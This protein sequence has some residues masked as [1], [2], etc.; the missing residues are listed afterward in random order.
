MTRALLTI[1]AALLL[2]PAVAAADGDRV[3]ILV[4]NDR[5]A[6]HR[7]TLRFAESDAQKM[8]DVLRA[9]GGF[10][11]ADVHVLLGGDTDALDAVLGDLE[12]RAIGTLLFYYSGHS[13]GFRLELGADAL[14]FD[15]LRARLEG[16]GARVRLVILDA[17]HSGRYVDVKGMRQGPSFDVSMDGDLNTS[18]TAVITSSALG[19]VSQESGRLGGGFFTHHLVS[20]LWGAADAD[21]DRVV[22]LLEA[23]DHA[24]ARTL[25]DTVE[26]PTGTQHP[27]Y[28]FRL[29]G[30]GGSL[31]MTTLRAG[32]A[33][34]GFPAG[35]EG[36]FFVIDDDRGG[37]VA[38]VVDPSRDTHLFLPPGEYRIVRRRGEAVDGGP[39]RLVAGERRN[40]DPEGFAQVS[41]RAADPRGGVSA[42]PAWTV[43]ALYGIS[44][45]FMN[46][47]GAFHQGV[48]VGMRRLGPVNLMVRASWGM[49]SVD[50]QGFRYDVQLWEGMAGV[51][52]R[53]SFYK[54]DLLLGPLVGGGALVQDAGPGGQHRASTFN[55]GALAGIDLWILEP[56]TIFASW[57]ADVLLFRRGEALVDEWIARAMVGVGVTF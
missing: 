31:P 25:A 19:E 44:S 8:A 2:S 52:W 43:A 5:G 17:C 10:A 34:L 20:G 50:E 46:R 27:S 26:S 54:L 13:D 35:L 22:T 40:V 12:G 24:F 30:R 18:G 47:M 37:V 29:K 48:L 15:A 7:R 53:F 49:D 55:A 56:L 36:A 39:V 51:L 3:A 45:K 11:A 6:G 16:T 41:H 57:E 1:L 42:S 21:D 23:Y 9:A 14:A 32:A 4:G 38:E 33:V 28:S